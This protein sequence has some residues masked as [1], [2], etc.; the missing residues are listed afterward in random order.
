LPARHPSQNA[1]G[2]PALL[3]DCFQI[4]F[5]FMPLMSITYAQINKNA[6]L[7]IAG[8]EPTGGGV[9]VSG[10]EVVEAEVRVELFAAIQIQIRCA[11][12]GD[13]RISE[14]V[15]FV[16]VGDSSPSARRFRRT[17]LKRLPLPWLWPSSSATPSQEPGE[18]PCPG[19][20]VEHPCADQ[21]TG[22]RMG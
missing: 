19:Q 16:G 10:A 13:Q 5:F 21:R 4:A 2:S 8:H 3:R 11:A 6:A 7:R 20:S 12:S 22:P 17:S 18:Q 9:V 1:T 15:I 14:G